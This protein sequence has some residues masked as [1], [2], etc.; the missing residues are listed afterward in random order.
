MT[1]GQELNRYKLEN[2]D[3]KKR[4]EEAEVGGALVTRFIRQLV[5][6]L[7]TVIRIQLT[8]NVAIFF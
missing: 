2:A 5:C 8:K 1:D 6:V 7:C 4:C 3:L